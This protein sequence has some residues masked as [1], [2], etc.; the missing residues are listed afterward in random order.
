MP[1]GQSSYQLKTKITAPSFTGT[2]KPK[3]KTSSKLKA[4]MTGGKC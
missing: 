1:T 2:K 4:K 3:P